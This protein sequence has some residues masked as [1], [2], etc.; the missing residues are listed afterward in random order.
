MDYLVHK[1]SLGL[2]YN[3][4][5]QHKAIICSTLAI[6][7]GI[8]YSRNGFLQ[9]F[10]RGLKNTAPRASVKVPDWNFQVVLEAH[11]RL[12]LNHFLT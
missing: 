11:P 4:L 9:R 6:T 2:R 1:A 10:M 8:N 5:Q 7:K 12:L 3:T